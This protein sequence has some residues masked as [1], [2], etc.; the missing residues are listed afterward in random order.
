MPRF[1]VFTSKKDLG[2]SEVSV[3]QSYPAFQVVSAT[4]E[5][6]EVLRQ[7][8]PVQRLPD[9]PSTETPT[10]FAAMASANDDRRGR[11]DWTISYLYP[12]KREWVRELSDLGATVLGSAGN[13]AVIAAVPNLEVL[14]DIERLDHVQSVE[15]HRV[16]I[17]I[18]PSFLDGVGAAS[19]AAEDLS[20][21]G[22]TRDAAVDPTRNDRRDFAIPGALYLDFYDQND[23]QAAFRR[24]HRYKIHGVAEAGPTR[25]SVDL[26]HSKDI[27][28]DLLTLFK[29]PGLRKIEQKKV[30]QLF[31]DKAREVI[32]AN[33][34]SGNPASLL[35]GTGE[36]VA[37]A[38]SGLDTG[39][40]QTVHADFRG[41]V[42]NI[43]S[44]PIAP[45]LAP[46]VTNPGG[47]DGASDD[48]SG[49]GTHVAGSVLGNG[50]R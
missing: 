24:L 21:A 19:G 22:A 35:T 9:P 6:A 36:I 42:V 47:D 30:K 11:R 38:D 5:A 8:Y 41:R 27:Q 44:W 3:E 32:G 2:N 20:D 48:F 18:D 33:V 14:A 10:A 43:E 49:H 23:A 13:S 1:K 39:D 29:C 7:S 15:L 26:S 4:V 17:D 45:S 12:I 34:V 31:N 37:V 25:L 46:F 28:E 16:A 40:A 50:S